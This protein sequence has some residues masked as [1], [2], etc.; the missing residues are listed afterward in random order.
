MK[1]MKV[2]NY[3]KPKVLTWAIKTETKML[4]Q[5][6]SKNCFHHA[7]LWKSKEK[8][9]TYNITNEESFFFTDQ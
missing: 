9:T 3:L 6:C 2:N 5:W 4:K 7:L 8:K 1:K